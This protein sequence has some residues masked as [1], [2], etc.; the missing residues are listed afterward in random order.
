VSFVGGRRRELKEKETKHQH[1]GSGQKVRNEDGETRLLTNVDSRNNIRLLLS[2]LP[3]QHD[4]PLV[5]LLI[6]VL[7]PNRIQQ[8]QHPPLPLPVPPH[9]QKRRLPDNAA[10]AVLVCDDGE[11]IAW[12]E[13]RHDEG[14]GGSDDARSEG[15]GGGGRVWRVEGKDEEE[16]ERR[17]GR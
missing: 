5:Y 4:Q 10:L 8:I 14:E 7:I 9:S 1:D 2:R 12:G 3:I 17:M 13:G 6:R 16:V 15:G 11:S